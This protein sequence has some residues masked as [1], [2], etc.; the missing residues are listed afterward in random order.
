MRP[1]PGEVY[2]VD[3]GM[4]AKVRP[5]V[6]V[7][8]DDPDP[9]RALVLCVPFTTQ[10]RGSPYEVAIRKPAYLREESWA[11]VQGLI[12][13]GKEKLERRLGQVTVDQLSQIRAALRFALEL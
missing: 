3:L 1:R 9:P 13:V 10:N 8:R 6:V 11:N 7:S 12:A 5:M 4:V 2:L